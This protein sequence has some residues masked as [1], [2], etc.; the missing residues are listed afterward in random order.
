MAGS[1]KYGD[2]GYPFG[3]LKASSTNP[4][5]NLI[6]MPYNYP[7]LV[8][9]LGLCVVVAAFSMS[10]FCRCWITRTTRSSPVPMSCEIWCT[11]KFGAPRNYRNTG[12][13]TIVERQVNK[14]KLLAN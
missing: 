10:T 1:G 4:V 3:Y 8:P 6:V 12:I 11:T 14:P 13:K 9:L 7:L 2:I 5:V